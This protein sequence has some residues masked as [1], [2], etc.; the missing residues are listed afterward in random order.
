MAKKGTKS[1]IDKKEL[2]FEWV[3]IDNK[4]K[5]QKGI[6]EA[7]SEANVRVALRTKGLIVKKVKKASNLSDKG[8]KITSAD[9]SVFTRQLA[10]MMRSGV[11]LLQSFDIVANGHSN[12]NVAKLLLDIK[13]AVETGSN[14]ADA[15][16]SHPQYFNDLFCSL[17]AAGEKAGILDLI[18]DKLAEYQEKMQGIKKKIKSALTY[19]IAVF[20]I[21]LIVSAILLIFVVPTFK[22]VFASFGAEL[23]AP[24]QFVMDLSDFVVGNWYIIVGI[25]VGIGFFIKHLF[26]TSE[27]VRN[28]WDNILLNLPIFGVIIRK[29]VV[30]RWC[31]TLATMFAAGV[32]LVEALD[33]VAGAS[34]NYVYS[35]ATKIIQS[36]VETGVSLTTTMQRQNVFPNMMIQMSQIGE[37]SGSLDAMLNKVAEFYE[38]EVDVAVDSLSS[39]M[40]PLIIAFLGVVIGGLV[41]AMYLPIF[42]MASTV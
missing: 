39:L 37:E 13:G 30:A 29:A 18:L 24:T 1:V 36:E 21:A 15:F 27:K 16:A 35:S 11:P 38:E 33:S 9:I 12:P 23:P 19:P 10:T 7:V 8:K 26:K 17:V 5:M 34:G 28:K 40:E 32:P 20:S 3:A 31:R 25:M 6:M 2:R 14:L 22:E 41:V 42:K 4:G